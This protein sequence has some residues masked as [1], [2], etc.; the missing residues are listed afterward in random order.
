MVDKSCVRLWC[1]TN[2]LLVQ[3]LYVPCLVFIG[4][5]SFSAML[6]PLLVKAL[7]V[8]CLVFIGASSFHAIFSLYWWKLFLC[9]VM[10][11]SYWCK[12]FP[13]C[14]QSLLV[15]ALSFL[16]PVLIDVSS[17]LSLSSPCLVWAL[18][19]LC[20]VLIGVNS[21]ILADV[22][23]LL[24]WALLFL[25][26]VLVGTSSFMLCLVLIDVSSFLSIFSPYGGRG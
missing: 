25:Y 16:C 9:N 24:M 4:A 15:W 17:F 8:P 5:S 19:L 2:H 3:A 1:N 6:M 23:S 12:L 10:F 21:K 20:S 22:Q 26:S 11:S 14:V 7:Y 13:F 18:S